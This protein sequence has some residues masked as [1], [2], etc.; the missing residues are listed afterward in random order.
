MPSSEA[1]IDAMM[2]DWLYEELDPAEADRFEQHLQSHPEARAE[3]DALKR[4][5]AAFSDLHEE[6]VEPPHSL[7]A[8]LM[9]EAARAAAPKETLW[10]RLVGLFQPIVLHPAASAMATVVVLVGVAGALYLR[11]GNMV[12]SP[13][14]DSNA[15]APAEVATLEAARDPAPPPRTPG[16][17][18]SEATYG[19]EEGGYE[20]GLADEDRQLAIEQA[21]RG[22]AAPSAGAGGLR[23]EQS[24]EGQRT[25]V[26]DTRAA[27]RKQ[28]KQRERRD[29]GDQ[30][31][32]G[33]NIQNSPIGKAE[34][35]DAFAPAPLKKG[36]SASKDDAAGPAG[37]SNE[38][39]GHWEQQ[40]NQNLQL[41]AQ[42]DR[43]EEVGRIANDILDRN[44]PFYKQEVA[45][46]KGASMCRDSI[47][48]ETQRRLSHRRE[49][50]AKRAKAKQGTSVPKK[51]P[52]A[53]AERAASES[54][55][56]L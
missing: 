1:E 52:A 21:Q 4:T 18:S 29:R 44:T 27:R 50:A 24:K 14:T 49:V 56:A 28:A 51:V 12:S 6:D 20:V 23:A 35:D 34:L 54:A 5:R 39:S 2:V 42:N 37:R 10:T 3:A 53:P 19:D 31:L 55:D 26:V 33:G 48:T 22:R 40:Q 43:C 7:T 8:I 15:S 47:A 41:A 30:G 13:R 9:H 32:V 25:R 36:A 16:G 38:K 45:K 17:D 46:T 11:H